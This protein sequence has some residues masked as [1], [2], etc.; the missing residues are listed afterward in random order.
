MGFNGGQQPPNGVLSQAFPTAPGQTYTVTFDFGA[1][2]NTSP[3]TEQSLRAEA[4]GKTVLG[5]IDVSD[6]A[7]NPITYDRHSFGFIADGTTALLTFTDT[8]SVTNNVDGALDRVIVTGP[9]VPRFDIVDLSVQYS[10]PSTLSGP[11]SF[12]LST[13]PDT[14]AATF[15][16]QGFSSAANIVAGLS[17]VAAASIRLGDGLWTELTS[18]SLVTDSTGEVTTLSYAIPWRRPP[19]SWRRTS[20]RGVTS[21]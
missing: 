8:S 19:Y 11:V 15:S 5:S 2:S 21:S 6:S 18:F 1:Y 7:S 16:L 13:L 9:L 20:S 17:D 14:F 4:T 10:L 12:G 3:G